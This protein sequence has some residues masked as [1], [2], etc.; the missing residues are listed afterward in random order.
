ME[1]ANITIHLG[2]KEAM[3]DISYTSAA[4]EVGGMALPSA[5]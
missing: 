1:K 3:G 2:Q 5:K 4:G